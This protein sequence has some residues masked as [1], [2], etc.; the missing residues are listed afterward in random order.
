MH[1]EPH[2][3]IYL[4]SKRNKN[5]EPTKEL[6]EAPNNAATTLNY[7]QA[8]SHVVIINAKILGN[9]SASNMSLTIARIITLFAYGIFWTRAHM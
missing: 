2:A 9:A 5:L 1:L 8:H 3:T 7:Q 6:F 4:T